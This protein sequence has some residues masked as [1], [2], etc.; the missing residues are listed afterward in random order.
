MKVEC[1]RE[2]CRIQNLGGYT[3]CLGWTPTYDKYGK[4][5][6]SDPNTTTWSYKCITCGKQWSETE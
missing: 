1:P 3:T 5:L 4:L 6:N 2:D